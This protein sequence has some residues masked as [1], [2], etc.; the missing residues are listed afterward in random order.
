MIYRLLKNFVVFFLFILITSCKKTTDNNGAEPPNPIDPVAQLIKTDFVIYVQDANR[1]PISDADVTIGGVIKKTNKLGIITFYETSVPEKGVYIKAVKKNYHNGYRI[2]IPQK[3]KANHIT[4]ELFEHNIEGTISVSGGEVITSEGVKIKL[5]ANAVNGYSGNIRLAVKYLDATDAFNIYRLPGDLFAVNA[6]NQVGMLESFGMISVDLLDASG[7]L[8]Q[9]ATGKQADIEIPVPDSKKNTAPTSIPLWHFDEKDGFWKID[10]A[11][12]LNGNKYVGKV[13]HF[14]WWNVDVFL[15]TKRYCLEPAIGNIKPDNLII[16]ALDKQSGMSVSVN[17]S[18]CITLPVN[19]D[20]SPRNWLFGFW[21]MGLAGEK[22][23]HI[24]TIEK[25]SNDVVNG[26]TLKFDLS[27][28]GK[29]RTIDVRGTATQC[30]GMPVINGMAIIRKDNE[31]LVSVIK[32]GAFN[33]NNQVICLDP[34]GTQTVELIVYDYSNNKESQTKLI[35]VTPDNINVGAILACETISDNYYKPYGGDLELYSQAAVDNFLNGKY[36][37]VLGNVH[38]AG[39][40]TSINNLRALSSLRSIAKDLRIES[41]NITTLEGL[42]NL[43]IIGGRLYFGERINISSFNGLGKLKSIGKDFV[44]AYLNSL[45][46]FEGLNSLTEINGDLYIYNWANPVLPSFVGLENLTKI[47]GNFM[48]EGNSSLQSFNGLK[49]LVEVRGSFT[50]QNMSKISSLGGFEKLSKIGGNVNITR[51]PLLQSLE[52]LNSLNDIGGRLWVTSNPLLYSMQGLNNLS[53]ISGDFLINDDKFVT[54]NGLEKLTK[55]G[56]DFD[57]QSKTLKSLSGL[58]NLSI[59][60]GKF[61]LFLTGALQSF[62][63]IE[64]LSTIGKSFSIQGPENINSFEGLT[65]LKSIGEDFTISGTDALSM[66]GLGNLSTIGG[67]FRVE[68][69]SKLLSFNGLGKLEKVGTAIRIVHNSSVQTLQG[70]NTLRNTGAVHISGNNNL[71]NYCALTPLL[72][73]HQNLFFEV[74][75]NKFNATRGG[76]LAGVCSQ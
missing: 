3:S 71:V 39:H 4:V 5:P 64:K 72:Q 30:N 46:S 58:D 63:G 47:G 34:A 51:N 61:S 67:I 68:E 54:L 38:I 29:I 37:H 44:I 32:D 2:I 60:E 65:G 59:I 43:A 13:S 55:I 48:C 7:N 56:G 52:G 41:T 40:F 16:Q 70:L 25:N 42:D 45:R 14:S 66:E 9:L 73:N 75:N 22:S 50:V 8:L 10:G 49:G 6:N 12:T 74:Y 53:L 19:A 69:S 36:T 20:G 24:A 26:S 76:M 21:V 57:L 23:C 1:K 18:G 17:G 33:F 27:Y 31:T 62:K 11:A 28:T 35:T 15:N